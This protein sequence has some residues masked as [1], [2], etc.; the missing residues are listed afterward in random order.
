[1]DHFPIEQVTYRDKIF[2]SIS[3]VQV[4]LKAQ[5][6]DEMIKKCDKDLKDLKNGK[7]KP[8]QDSVKKTETEI[9]SVHDKITKIKVS[10][11]G[12]C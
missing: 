4:S 11:K 8:H 12:H 7:L 1:M 3:L 2:L 10:L 6:K 9:D 5:K